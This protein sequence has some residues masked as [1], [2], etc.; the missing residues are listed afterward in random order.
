MNIRDRF[1]EGLWLWLTIGWLGLLENVVFILT[2][3]AWMPD[4][5]LS[6]EGRRLDRIERREAEAA[7]E[8]S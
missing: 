6:M 8:K 5:S 3:T 2:F 1:L 4:W 7:E